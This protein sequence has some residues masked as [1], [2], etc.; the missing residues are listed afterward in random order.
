MSS[1]NGPGALKGR[2]RVGG[3]GISEETSRN[4]KA[5]IRRTVNASSPE[6]FTTAAA[7]DVPHLACPD[8][9]PSGALCA[10]GLPAAGCQCTV[11][12][13]FEILL[14]PHPL[15]KHMTCQIDDLP[16]SA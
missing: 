8:V 16:T 9:C 14:T 6:S 2:G 10:I 5:R 15:R 11:L 12:Q 13:Q 7:T 3:T 1:L 4:P